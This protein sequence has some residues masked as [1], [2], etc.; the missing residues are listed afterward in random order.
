MIIGIT[1]LTFS[2]IISILIYYFS[3]AYTLWY[4]FFVPFI[5]IPLVFVILFVIMLVVLFFISLSFNVKKPL[6]KPSRIAL[7]FVNNINYL[8]CIFSR[9]KIKI[10]NKDDMPLED[11]II[12]ANH[13]SNFDPMVIMKEYHY[14]KIY[15]VSKLENFSIPICGPFIYKAGFIPLERDN[16]KQE[17]K[18]IKMAV[19]YL[20]NNYGSIYICPEGT[21][22]KDGHLLPFHPGSFKLALWSKK[23]IVVISVKN[24]N[25]IHKNFPF[26]R[27]N[28]TLNVLKV[29]PY[30]EYM[31]KT[32]LELSE[33]TFN[34]I[35]NDL[36]RKN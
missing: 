24:T 26:K 30:E 36:E 15:C 22:S 14:K 7:F 6:K 33:Y 19:S 9:T 27:T 5:S 13:V 18:A 10:I 4:L 21:R 20:D 28:V 29:I 32:A 25:M 34:L 3:S 17:M 31:N 11:V 35:K 2:L 23:P 12:I 16:L 8:L 1:L